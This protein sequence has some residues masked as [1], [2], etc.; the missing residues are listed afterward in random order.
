[1]TAKASGLPPRKHWRD[2]LSYN[3]RTHPSKCEGWGTRKSRFLVAMLLGMTINTNK[4]ESPGP[5][6]CEAAKAPDVHDFRRGKQRRAPWATSC[7]LKGRYKTATFAQNA[8]G[9]GTQA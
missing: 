7:R 3:D 5:R 2:D 4:G 1:M 8:K 9:G 6:L